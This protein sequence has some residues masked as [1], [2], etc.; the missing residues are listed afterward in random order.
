MWTNIVTMCNE[1]YAVA[2]Q[3]R[4]RP[5]IG[6]KIDNTN[7]AIFLPVVLKFQVFVQVQGIIIQVNNVQLPNKIPSTKFACENAEK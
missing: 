1:V 3:P 4:R 2:V 6:C 5:F 7:A